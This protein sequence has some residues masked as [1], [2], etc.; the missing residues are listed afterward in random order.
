M[1]FYRKLTNFL[2]R[3][4][5]TIIIALHC[6]LHKF[7][8]LTAMPDSFLRWWIKNPEIFT[9]TQDVFCLL[10]EIWDKSRRDDEFLETSSRSMTK[11]IKMWPGDR[12]VTGRVIR[13]IAH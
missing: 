6:T 5:K 3:K 7:K 10:P 1:P 12:E 9:M 11:K 8:T 4:L 2:D 13:T